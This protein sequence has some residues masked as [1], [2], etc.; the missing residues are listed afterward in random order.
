MN[1]ESAANTSSGW[2]HQRSRRAVSPNRRRPMSR[3]TADSDMPPPI[4]V[5]QADD[6]ALTIPYLARDGRGCRDRH[7]IRSSHA[8]SSS[9]M[10]VRETAKRSPGGVRPH[11]AD[12][13]ASRIIS[14]TVRAFSV[15]SN[16]G[17]GDGMP[18]QAMPPV[19]QAGKLE[20]PNEMIPLPFTFSSSDRSE[21]LRKLSDLIFLLKMPET[22]I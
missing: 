15:S 4:P 17:T 19:H 8:T 7:A 12:P 20:D 10:L 16:V 21:R 13:C 5:P 14:K 3:G 9:S 18:G 1:V 11:V 22:I 2:I 6:F